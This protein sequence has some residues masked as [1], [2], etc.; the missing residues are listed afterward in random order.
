MTYCVPTAVETT[1]T[2]KPQNNMYIFA[3]YSLQSKFYVPFTDTSYK[4]KLADDVGNCT[5]VGF[6]MI[7]SRPT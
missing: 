6:A 4:M 5:S 3:V 7:L 2:V 1:R